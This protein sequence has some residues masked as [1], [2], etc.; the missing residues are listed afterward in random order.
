MNDVSS[1]DETILLLES[2]SVTRSVLC[3]ALERA[4]H[5][6][7]TASDLGE[8]V[9][10]LDEMQ[11]DLLIV[12]PYI[13]SMPAHMA[14]DYLRSRHPGLHVLV[15]AGLLDDDRIRVRNAIRGFKTFR[16]AFA[17]DEFVT[18]VKEV[19]KHKSEPLVERGTR[20]SP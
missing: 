14:A 1:V 5:L 17:R 16:N 18:K 19:L 2:D 15:V 4:G 3:E 9:D 7:I 11:S 10:R 13:S 6:V 8:A 20:K 12:S